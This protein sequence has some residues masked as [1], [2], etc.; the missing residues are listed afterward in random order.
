MHTTEVFKVYGDLES[1]TCHKFCFHLDEHCTALLSYLYIVNMLA[2]R[3]CCAEH[4]SHIQLCG[5]ML[6]VLCLHHEKNAEHSTVRLISAAHVLTQLVP[7]L[8]FAFDPL[9]VA[10]LPMYYRPNFPMP[11]AL[12]TSPCGST[13]SSLSGKS[14]AGYM[15]PGMA[16][17]GHI[18]CT[19]PALP[20]P[21]DP[22][23]GSQDGC[24]YGIPMQP[25]NSNLYQSGSDVSMFAVKGPSRVT[26]TGTP[27]H[28]LFL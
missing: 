23:Y 20:P 7:T 8:C 3:S 18:Y 9:S 11:A 14:Q 4:I 12:P 28:L 19:I 13:R 10:D 5:V 24:V 25:S 1:K 2:A 21:Q 26:L 22:M 17:N 6:E 16:N 15:S 27:I